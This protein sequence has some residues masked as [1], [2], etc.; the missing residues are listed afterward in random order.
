MGVGGGMGV[1]GGMGVVDDDATT[2]G[3]EMDRNGEYHDDDGSGGDGRGGAT[4]A[5]CLL[6]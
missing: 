1:E 2:A 6:Y 4:I 5:A 3:G